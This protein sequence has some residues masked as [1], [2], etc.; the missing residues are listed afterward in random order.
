MMGNAMIP[1]PIASMSVNLQGRPQQT[2]SSRGNYRIAAFA[3]GLKGR[4]SAPVG[5]MKVSLSPIYQP[6]RKDPPCALGHYQKNLL[7]VL[8][9]EKGV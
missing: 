6:V 1:T 7:V 3:C 4:G 5:R 2:R 8:G 9:Y